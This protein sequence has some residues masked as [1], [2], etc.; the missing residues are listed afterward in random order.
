MQRL[1]L[2][3]LL[4]SS[5]TILHAQI[6]VDVVIN[7]L[8]QKL[9]DNVRLF[10]SI[11]QQKSHALMSEGRLLRLHKKASQEINRALQPFGYYRPL[12]SAE[13]TRSGADKWRASYTID[14]GPALL[15]SEFNLIT[16]EEMHG[17]PVFEQLMQN[18]PLAIGDVFN[19]IE[20]ENIKSSLARVASE[21]GY[22]NARFTDHRVDID[23]DAYTARI[24]LNYNSG[25]RYRFGEVLLPQNVLN[26]DLLRRYLPFEKG[27]PYT[28][29]QLIDLQHALNDSD[30]FRTAEVSLGEPQPG[31]NEIPVNVLLTPRKPNRYSFGLGYGSDTGT[32]TSFGWSI[33]LLNPSGHRFDTEAKVSEIGHTVSVRYRVPV[34]NPRTDQMIYSAGIVNEKTDTNESTIRTVGASLKRSRGNWRESISLNYQ[35]EDFVVGNDRGDSTLLMPGVNWTR[36]W[37]NSFIYAIDGLRF[38]IGL[39]GASEGLLSDTDFSQLE[40]GIKAISSFNP[41]NRI[42]A[43]AK[44][45]RIWTQEFEQLPSSV[46]FF[47]GGAQSVRGYA[48]ESLSPVDLNGAAVGGLYLVAGSIEYEH[49]FNDK[50]G[51]ALFF[52]SGNAVDNL[53]DK[54]ES[55]AGFGLRWKSPVGPVRIDLASAISRDGQPWRLHISIG[56]DL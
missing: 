5:S 31:S 45:G 32:R 35:Q 55:G 11:E 44:L 48:Y 2:I 9:E 53:N 8:D 1:L 23:L 50:W 28:V 56:P 29:D 47:A 52:D 39:R 46:R 18:L 20:Y 33:P 42:I 6:T 13:L 17:D 27:T 22:F 41:Y 36:I 25:P 38:D 21:R 14:P 24:Q 43:R 3:L 37:G 40:G 16:S 49:S 34:L 12:I 51:M 4:C 10:L 7:G 19:H 15:I 54:L 30:Y 26:D